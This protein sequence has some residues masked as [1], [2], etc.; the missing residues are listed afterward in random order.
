LNNLKRRANTDKESV[1]RLEE[2]LETL[3]AKESQLMEEEA[4]LKDR[5]NKVNI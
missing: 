5:T 3:K 1:L 4:G 2:K